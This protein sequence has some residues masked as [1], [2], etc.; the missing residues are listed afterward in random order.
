[1]M[2]AYMMYECVRICMQACMYTSCMYVYTYIRM[3][4]NN[5]YIHVNLYIYITAVLCMRKICVCMYAHNTMYLCIK[6]YVIGYM[7]P[8]Q[9]CIHPSMHTLSPVSQ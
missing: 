3:Y 9:P 5:M 2:H 1:M 8:N 7:D 4:A 6:Y